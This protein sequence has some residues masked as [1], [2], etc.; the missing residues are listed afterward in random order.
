MTIPD[1][2]ATRDRGVG[3]PPR[4]RALSAVLRFKIAVTALLWC[5]PLLLVPVEYLQPAGFPPLGPPVFLQLLGAA[6]LAL[7]V[8]YVGGLRALRRGQP[9]TD[10]V[11]VGLVS[12]ALGCLLAVGYGLAGE[13]AGW[14]PLAQ[15]YMWIS[16]A[17]AGLVT[18]G[19]AVYGRR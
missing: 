2:A 4:T 15:A 19:L 17:A 18:L 10:V 6:Y 3:T 5:I 1:A 16:A 9:V 13:Y 14:G 11:A 12:N 7:L 8:G